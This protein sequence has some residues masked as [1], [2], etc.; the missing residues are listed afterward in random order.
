[1]K[2][3]EYPIELISPKRMTQKAVML[4]KILLSNGLVA[5]REDYEVD[6]G[7]HQHQARGS[8][9]IKEQATPEDGEA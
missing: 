4:P 5:E 1:M 8:E 7:T 2:I 9:D 6:K 3:I